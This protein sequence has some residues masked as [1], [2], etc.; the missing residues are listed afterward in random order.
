[1][2]PPPKCVF[3]VSELYFPIPCTT[4]TECSSEPFAAATTATVWHARADNAGV[5]NTGRLWKVFVFLV[6]GNIDVPL[7]PKAGYVQP[8]TA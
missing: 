3:D 5:S 8:L 4:W 1:M 2:E 7:W 6:G